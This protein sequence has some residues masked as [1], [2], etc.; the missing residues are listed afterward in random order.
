[1]RPSSPKSPPVEGILTPSASRRSHRRSAPS[2]NRCPGSYSYRSAF[3]PVRKPPRLTRSAPEIKLRYTPIA[4]RDSD[5]FP[6]TLPCTP[7]HTV[8]RTLLRWYGPLVSAVGRLEFLFLIPLPSTYTFYLVP[9]MAS[10]G[11][12]LPVKG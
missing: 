8:A 11:R 4:R 10:D 7:A 12:F 6:I 1:V 5:F 9:Q 3:R 2:T